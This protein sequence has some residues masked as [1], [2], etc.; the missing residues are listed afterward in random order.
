MFILEY[1]HVQDETCR[2]F[3]I[4]SACKGGFEDV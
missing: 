4:K 3:L 1:F 2:S